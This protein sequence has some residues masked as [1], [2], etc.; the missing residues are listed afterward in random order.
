M[1]G[2]GGR[3]T[4]LG[5]STGKSGMTPERSLAVLVLLVSSVAVLVG[6]SSSGGSVASKSKPGVSTT[7]TIARMTEV[8]AGAGEKVLRYRSIE[9]SVPEAWPVGDDNGCGP[10]DNVGVFLQRPSGGSSSCAAMGPTVDTVHVG[11]LTGFPP[12]PAGQAPV[13][14]DE[15]A[16]PITPGGLVGWRFSKGPVS[17]SFWVLFPDEQVQLLFTFGGSPKAVERVLATVHRV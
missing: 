5:R 4:A 2:V 13:I 14:N 16:T 3:Q 17:S 9:F 15:R 6:C 7:T 1:C 11:P 8:S 12:T 10:F